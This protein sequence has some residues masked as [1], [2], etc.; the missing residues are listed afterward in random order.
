ML[1]EYSESLAYETAFWLQ[2]VDDPE[3]P[4]EELGRLSL[5]VSERFRALAI[6][7]LLS[8]GSVDLFCHN[9]IRSGLSRRTS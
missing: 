8:N 2:G 6:I 1:A 9:L 4:L 7:L 3:F 5:E